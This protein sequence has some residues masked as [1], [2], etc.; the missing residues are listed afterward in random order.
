M[1]LPREDATAQGLDPGRGL[2]PL[3]D[4]AT[5]MEKATDHL[6]KTMV[7]WDALGKIHSKYMQIHLQTWEILG[8]LGI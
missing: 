4:Q 2:V 5:A 7:N 8:I 1:P 3:A 6:G